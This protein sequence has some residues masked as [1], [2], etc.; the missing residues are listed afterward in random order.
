LLYRLAVMSPSHI[1]RVTKESSY[2]PF[3]SSLSGVRD[4][5]QERSR[6]C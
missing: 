2:K 4:E 3:E 5:S 6:H 1:C